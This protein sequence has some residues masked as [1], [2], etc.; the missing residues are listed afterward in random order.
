MNMQYLI[1]LKN[2]KIQESLDWKLLN[3][4]QMRLVIKIRNIC[5]DGI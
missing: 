3:V 4:Y 1:F 2:F 5:Y